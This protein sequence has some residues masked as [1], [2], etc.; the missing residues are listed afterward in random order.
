MARM[1]RVVVP[2]FPHH[3][4]QRGNYGQTVFSSAIERRFYLRLLRER[5]AEYRLGVLAYC[6]MTN[7]VHLVVVPE[8]EDSMHKALGR[9]HNDY[10][11][12]VHIQRGVIG[13]LWQNRYYSCVL[14]SRH[15]WAAIRY[16]E[17]NP[18]RAGLI[19]EAWDWQWSSAQAHV[20]GEDREQILDMAWWREHASWADWRDALLQGGSGT[21]LENQI[22]RATRTG[23]PLGQEEFVEDLERQ[24]GRRIRPAKRGPKPRTVSEESQLSFGVA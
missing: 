17:L 9:A 7:H 23:R 14:E 21:E 18:V 6:L 2:G 15:L 12:C 11:R 1:A 24:L 4:T 5:C 20:S 19:S 8:D 10:S 13:H 16:V 3:V 22:R